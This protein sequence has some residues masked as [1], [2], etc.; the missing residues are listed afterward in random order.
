[1]LVSDDIAAEYNSVSEKRK[2][3]ALLARKGM[4]LE[5]FQRFI[6]ALI[7]RSVRVVPAGEPPPCRDENDRKYLHCAVTA[8]VDALVSYDDDLLVLGTIEGI[9]IL[10]PAVFLARFP[11]DG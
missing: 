7:R 9:P 11:T 1:M 8:G 5:Y 10:P 4:G 2:V 6:A 3:R